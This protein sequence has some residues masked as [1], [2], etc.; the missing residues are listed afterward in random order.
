MNP[1]A[2]ILRALPSLNRHPIDAFDDADLVAYLADV[3]VRHIGF[4]A[5]CSPQEQVVLAFAHAAG[6][7]LKL[8]PSMRNAVLDAFDRCVVA[9]DRDAEKRRYAADVHA[10]I[11]QG[12]A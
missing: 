3:Q 7:L 11:G 6:E 9:V 10:F 8:D 4:A 12:V 1:A 5:V 2:E